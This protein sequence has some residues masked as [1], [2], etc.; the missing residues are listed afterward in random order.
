MP[1]LLCIVGM[2]IYIYID[3]Y[4]QYEQYHHCDIYIICIGHTHTLLHI[5][6]NIYVYCGNIPQIYTVYCIYIYPHISTKLNHEYIEVMLLHAQNLGFQIWRCDG[7]KTIRTLMI[8]FGVRT[9]E[10]QQ[11]PTHLMTFFAFWCF[12]DL[13]MYDGLNMGVS[14]LWMGGA[15]IIYSPRFAWGGRPHRRFISVRERG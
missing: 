9:S 1:P 7:S 6:Y 4:I 8:L 10:H 13:R 5:L 12:N 11:E 3:N 2:Y 14:I 15:Q